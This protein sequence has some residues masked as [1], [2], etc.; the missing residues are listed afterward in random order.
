MNE[1]ISV[2]QARRAILERLGP[3]GAE[4]VL[5]SQAAGRVLA[6]AVPAPFDSP[7]FTNSA[8]DG[9]A[10]RHSDIG[11]VGATLQ[12]VGESAAGRR[13]DGGV[14][15]GQAVRIATGAAL[16]DGADTVVMQEDVEAVDH[17]TVRVPADAEPAGAWVRRRGENLSQGQPA[18]TAGARLDPASVGLLAS[19]RRAVVSV[20]RRP[21]VAIVSTGDELVELDET[22]GDDAIVNSNAYM[23]EALCR[24]AGA[25]ATVLPIAPDDRDAIEATYRQ[26]IAAADLVVSSGGVSVGPHDHTR[27]V[28]E[29]LS[30]SMAF[31]KIRMKPGKPL[32]FGTTGGERST[33]LIG[34]PGNPASSLVCFHQFVRP[35]LARL[36][37]RPADALASRRLQATLA[38]GVDSTPRRREYLSGT[39][40]HDDHGLRFV[41]RQPQSSG[42]PA[43]FCG[44]EAFGIVEEGVARLETGA[45]IA[46][47]P[48]E[49]GPA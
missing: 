16:P 41:P 48:I 47:E 30:A 34:L 36:E 9:Y 49:A 25:V 40:E 12:V 21:R 3:L 42:N 23:L 43:L 15:A 18:L 31:W 29:S 28:L 1:F 14:E 8:R 45:G 22:P 39:L 5:V 7:P 44:A 19:F 46:V 37:G 13:F 35:A 27:V 11:G 4:R 10:I 26:A 2:D 33:G 32:A 17:A 6:E 38:T 24:Q 20:Y